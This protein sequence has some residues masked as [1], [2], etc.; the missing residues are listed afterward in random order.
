MCYGVYDELQK[1]FL[2]SPWLYGAGVFA[3]EHGPDG[4]D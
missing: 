1:K 4:R 3:D 2:L